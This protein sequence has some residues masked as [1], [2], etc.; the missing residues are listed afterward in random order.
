[1]AKS[2]WDKLPTLDS[3]LKHLHNWITS[4]NRLTKGRELKY[5]IKEI[6]KGAPH[7][8]GGK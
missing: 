7:P 4:K 8:F 2:A 3:D 1:M 5:I 6:A